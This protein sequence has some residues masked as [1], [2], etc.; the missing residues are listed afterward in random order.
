LMVVGDIE[1]L[2]RQE[3]QSWISQQLRAQLRDNHSLKISAKVHPT[4]NLTGIEI[5]ELAQKDNCIL[6][7]DEEADMSLFNLPND[8]MYAT[9]QPYLTNIRHEDVAAH[10]Y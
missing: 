5:E 7:V 3:P 8:P 9:S 4:Q 2:K 1:C 10:L 6:S